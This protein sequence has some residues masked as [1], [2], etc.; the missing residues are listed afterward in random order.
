VELDARGRPL[1]AALV[2]AEA[3]ELALVHRA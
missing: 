1:G 2:Q 3:P